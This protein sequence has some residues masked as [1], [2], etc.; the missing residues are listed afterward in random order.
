M[1]MRDAGGLDPGDDIDRVTL[2]AHAIK[3]HYGPGTQFLDVTHSLAVAA[4]FALHQLGFTETR[5]I[6]GLPGGPDPGDVRVAHRIAWHRPWAI[7]PGVLY[8]FDVTPGIG[9]SDLRHGVM[10]DLSLAPGSFSSSARVRA[11]QACLLHGD[12]DHDGGDLSRWIVPG[13]PLLIG[14]PLTGCPNLHARTGALFPPVEEDDWYSR[15]VSLPLTPSLVR[16]TD[17]T[18]FEHAVDVTLYDSGRPESPTEIRP[19]GGLYDRIVVSRPALLFDAC[20][21]IVAATSDAPGVWPKLA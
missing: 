1:S 6:Y 15:F 4:W 11:Q 17:S 19:V 20:R 16:S 13:T 21:S 2:W 3:Q 10:F 9:S 7:E 5:H 14:W 12:G 8:A 18:V